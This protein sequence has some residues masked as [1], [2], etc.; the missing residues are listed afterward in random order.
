MI[1]HNPQSNIRDIRPFCRPLCCQ[2]GDVK[3]TILHLSYSEPVMRLDCQI[4]L[5]S[6]PPTLRAG[7]GPVLHLNVPTLIAPGVWNKVKVGQGDWLFKHVPENKGME[8]S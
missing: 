6:P 4:L 7:S 3:Y 5:K 1:L 2:S 8:T